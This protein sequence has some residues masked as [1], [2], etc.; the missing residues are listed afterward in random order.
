MPELKEYCLS[1]RKSLVLNINLLL[2]ERRG[3]DGGFACILLVVY[4]QIMEDF[5]R[6]LNICIKQSTGM[7]LLF[8]AAG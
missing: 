8:S 4:V 2:V 1:E 7:C 3:S 6:M 5:H